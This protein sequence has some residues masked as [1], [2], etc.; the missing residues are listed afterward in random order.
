MKSFPAILCLMI[1]IQVSAQHVIR[2]LVTNAGNG[3]PLP[4]ANVYLENNPSRGSVTNNE[5]YFSLRL[6]DKSSYKLIISFIGF[7]KRIVEVKPGYINQLITI[8][9]KETRKVLTELIVMPEDAL[10]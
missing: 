1:G 9:L 4:Y 3:A 10:K 2:G 8:E 6:S 5:G 7:D